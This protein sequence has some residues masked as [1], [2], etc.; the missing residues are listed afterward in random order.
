MLRICW[1]ITHLL[2]VS[3]LLFFQRAVKLQREQTDKSIRTEYR[4][5]PQTAETVESF[6][7]FAVP[8]Y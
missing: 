4:G 2:G 7:M 5:V 1:F 6:L 8:Q 3:H